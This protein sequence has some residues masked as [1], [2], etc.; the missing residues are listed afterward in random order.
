MQNRL[1]SHP[2]AVIEKRD[3]YLSCGS[4]PQRNEGSL[5]HSGLPSQGLQHQEE[6]CPQILVVKSSEEYGQVRLR[7]AGGAGVPLKGSKHNLT[8]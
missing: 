1:V 2:Y 4:T 6:K 7:V 5:S 8:H 3:G